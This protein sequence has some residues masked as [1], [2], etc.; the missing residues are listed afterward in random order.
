MRLAVEWLLLF[1]LLPLLL[2]V[3]FRLPEG[4][5]SPAVPRSLLFG[6]LWVATLAVLIH[7]RRELRQHLHLFTI[8]QAKPILLRFVVLGGMLT[9]FAWL[10]LPERFLD[11]PQD[12]TGLWLRIMLLYPLLS[13]IPQE[14]IYRLFFHH[15]YAPLFPTT[16]IMMLASGF[17]FGHAHLLFGNWVAYVLSIA[18]GLLFASTYLKTRN[19]LL[20]MLEHALYGQLIFTV[21][22]G[23]LFY[24]GAI[25]AG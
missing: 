16:L 10:Y 19:L 3:L 14:V 24:S 5:I 7:R 20:T 15:R 12:R 25:T 17:S 9:L 21:G 22:L 2:Y 4:I 8:Q 1:G 13:V 11:L 23:T 6:G 18:G